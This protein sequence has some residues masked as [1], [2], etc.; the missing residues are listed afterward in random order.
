M[1]FT[2]TVLYFFLTMSTKTFYETKIYLIPKIS[3]HGPEKF[4]PFPRDLLP[5]LALP[6]YI[7]A[8]TSSLSAHLIPLHLLQNHGNI[9]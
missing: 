7:R 4:K 3:Q 9:L 2:K 8:S 1:C 5:R 6:K